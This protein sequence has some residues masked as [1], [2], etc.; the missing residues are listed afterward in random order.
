MARG[1]VIV[2]IQNDYFPGGRHELV[3]PEQA[4][5][6]AAAV[7]ARFRQRGEPVF[8]VQHVWE[9]E[10]AAFFSPGTPGV[11]IHEAVRPADGEPVVQKAH[12]NS[13]R[14]TDLLRR[15]R[16]AD[17]TDVVVAGMMTSMCV[18]ATVRA[19]ADLG[20]GCTV[21]HDACATLDLEFG[22]RTIPAA[23]V[24]GAFIAALGDSYATVTS[25]DDV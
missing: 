15:L 23:S 10:D 8:H 6:R 7:L 16:D 17:V 1:L 2:D 22:G 4:A 12:P 11:E 24:H 5:E 21:V 25:S 19:A 3:G 9:G 20:F 18:D 13:F 14:E